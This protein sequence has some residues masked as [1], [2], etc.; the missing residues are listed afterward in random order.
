MTPRLP[1]SLGHHHQADIFPRSHQSEPDPFSGT[2]SWPRQQFEFDTDPAEIQ[3][4]RRFHDLTSHRSSR[5]WPIQLQLRLLGQVP[6]ELVTP[7]LEN[8]WFFAASYS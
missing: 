3:S 6:F 1:C 4:R 8:H 7:A 2:L 5:P